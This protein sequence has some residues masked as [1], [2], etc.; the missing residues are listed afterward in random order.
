MEPPFK[1]NTELFDNKDMFP[2][3]E[4]VVAGLE[5]PLLLHRVIMAKSSK[6]VEG[7]LKAKQSAK[8]EDSSQI[9]WPFDIS[10]ER[11]R[12]VLVKVL[13]FCYD[14][15]MTVD[16]KGGELCAVIAALCRLQVS[17]LEEMIVKLT[18]FAVEHAKKDV[19]L[20]K[21]LLKETQLYPE[22]C[23]PNS[24]ELDKALAKVVLTRRNIDNNFDAVV[25]DCLMKLPMQFLD[26]AE[27]G[28]PHTQFS[29]FNVRARYV[30]E[31]CCDLS[32]GEKEIVMKKCDWTMLTSKE[33]MTLQELGV[34]GKEAMTEARSKALDNI[35]K[36]R[37]EYKERFEQ[38][39]ERFERE[40]ECFEQEKEK[41]K[42]K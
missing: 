42:S 35:E 38:E 6:F 4:F 11:D 13:Q 34:L 23:N 26:M 9:E 27:Y 30:K 25:G 18:E 20:G 16:A 32:Q 22:C 41:S 1:N 5:K 15:T 31:H 12:V 8:T 37:Y 40:K 33:L 17:H 19:N 3:L 39:K 2:D 24:V 29:E 28:E 10:N 36:E 14:K 7:L 21:E